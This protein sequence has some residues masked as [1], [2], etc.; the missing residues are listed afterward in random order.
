[1]NRRLLASVLA[2]ACT[3]G[4][5]TPVFAQLS[6]TLF[7][8]PE[9]RAYLDYL[10]QDF[11]A[12]SRERGF[13][14]SEADIPDIPV[15][16]VEAQEA[17]GPVIYT[18]GGIVT[19]R[20]GTQRIWLNG[21]AL[22]AAELPD[23]ARLVHEGGMPALRFNTDAG[24][25]L[26]R[27]GQTLELTAGSVVE[28]YQRPVETEPATPPPADTPVAA[29]EDQTPVAAATAPDAAGEPVAADQVVD[30]AA[31]PAGTAPTQE[32]IEEL[33]DLLDTLQPQEG[34]SDG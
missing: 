5:S 3:V 4:A 31:V 7:T 12:S 26:L 11:L 15:A 13:D 28:N 9:Q 1:M 6:G 8:S 21:K 16:V 34:S 17:E 20:D 23:V 27:P 19:L 18:L 22:G 2:L 33:R 29:A 14:I 10:R 24:S 32:S 30:P 25:V